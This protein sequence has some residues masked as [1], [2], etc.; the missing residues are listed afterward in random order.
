MNIPIDS[1]PT[2]AGVVTAT[3]IVPALFNIE[4]S[5]PNI[6]ADF[7]FSI[8]I[9]PVEAFVNVPLLAAIAI[10]LSPPCIVIVL[11]FV[12]VVCATVLW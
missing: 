4:D 5:S 8:L 3:L 10:A 6:P 12:A 2:G 9:V 7:E 11:L 1:E